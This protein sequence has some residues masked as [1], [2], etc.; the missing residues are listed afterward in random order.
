MILAALAKIE[1][2]TGFAR[3]RIAATFMRLIASERD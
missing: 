3:Y 2:K 1:S